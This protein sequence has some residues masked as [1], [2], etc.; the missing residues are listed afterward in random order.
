[1]DGATNV[2][3]PDSTHVQTATSAA[4][5][6]EY[7]KFLTNNP[8]AH[9]IV[10]Q[11]GPIEIAGKALNFPQNTGLTDATI[12]I[13]QVN[14]SGRRTTTAPL[15]EISGIDSS[16]QWGPVSVTAG[17]HYEFAIVRTG[18]PTLHVY[19]E[20][21]VR[22]D[23]AVRLLDSD[24]LTAYAG[25]RPGSQSAVMIRYKELWGDQAG[26]SDRLL[27]NGVN[28][29]V[30]NLCPISKQ[31]NALFVF[32]VNRDGK[33]ELGSP[34]PAVSQLPFLTGADVFI[35]ASGAGGTPAGT[36]TFQLFSRGAGTARTVKSPNWDSTTD[37]VIVQWND[38]ELPLAPASGKS[39][40]QCAKRPKITWRIHQPVHGRIVR[41][42][43]FVDGR[44]VKRLHGHRI[45]RL[46]LKRPAG[47]TRFT[48]RI[49]T[50][51]NRGEKTISVRHY[52][53][54]GKTAPHTHTHHH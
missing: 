27:I 1:M 47:K 7:Y 52:R 32:D 18:H 39:G 37:G 46:R 15:H 25:N 44:L 45:T 23:Y 21:F 24:A 35:P 42:R 10:P 51:G 38:F 36:T 13:W 6:V 33:T 31:V 34:D 14:S 2:T 49:V 4:S 9:D 40:A 12:E 26:E 43:A 22:S 11:T 29:C 48:V 17:V 5:F 54:C 30:P 28:V 16:G 19:Y 3:I 50:Y 41:V 20:P 53:R 8:P